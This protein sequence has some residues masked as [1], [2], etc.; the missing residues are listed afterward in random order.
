MGCSLADDRRAKHLPALRTFNQVQVVQ[1]MPLRHR[2]SVVVNLCEFRLTTRTQRQSFFVW[3]DFDFKILRHGVLQL[4]I[5]SAVILF[6]P[7]L[8][9]SW[10]RDD[11]GRNNFL[12]SSNLGSQFDV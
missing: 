7:G 3:F 6:S 5:V 9:A 2:I 10:Y 11:A 4:S 8:Q 12:I 1:E